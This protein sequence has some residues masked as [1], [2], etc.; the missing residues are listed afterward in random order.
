[1]FRALRKVPPG[2]EEDFEMLSSDSMIKQFGQVTFAVRT[3]LALVSSIALLAAGV[4]IMNI[5]LSAQEKVTRY[6]EPICSRIV[7]TAKQS[8]WNVKYALGASQ[9][10]LMKRQRVSMRLRCGL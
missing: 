7:V 2:E 8:D 9:R 10:C 3:G 6:S 5:M 1:L 4:G